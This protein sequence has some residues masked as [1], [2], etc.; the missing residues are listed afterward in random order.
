[1]KRADLERNVIEA[2]QA[3]FLPGLHPNLI[4]RLRD[5]RGAVDALRAH[6]EGEDPSGPD[7]N[8]AEV[9][10]ARAMGVIYGKHV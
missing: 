1:M 4:R 3:M 5:L 6:D 10:A 8:E 2:A 9:Q 7:L